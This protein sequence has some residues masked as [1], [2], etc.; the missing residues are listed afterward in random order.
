MGRDGK[1]PRQSGLSRNEQMLTAFN[2]YRT[3]SLLQILDQPM[4]YTFVDGVVIDSLA[5]V[6]SADPVGLVLAVDRTQLATL[7]R[8]RSV[9]L[10]SPVHGATFHAT[11]DAVNHRRAYVSLSAL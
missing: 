5:R 1:T 4:T 9:L 7:G 8:K 10:E 3:T 2:V 11:V 6:L